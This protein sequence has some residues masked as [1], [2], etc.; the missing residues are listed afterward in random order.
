MFFF[1]QAVKDDLVISDADVDSLLARIKITKRHNRKF[2]YW[3]KVTIRFPFFIYF[4]KLSDED[5]AFGATK[6][7]GRF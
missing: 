5:E 3:S 2:I 7:G 1:I 4:T 6:S